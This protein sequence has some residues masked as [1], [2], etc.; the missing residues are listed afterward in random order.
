MGC[1]ANSNEKKEE[2]KNEPVND[3]SRVSENDM[4]QLN[5]KKQIRNIK[6]QRVNVETRA[7][8]LKKDAIKYKSE[9]NNSKAIY[10][11]KLKKLVEARL[12]KFDGAEL[13]LEQTLQQLQEATMNA[14]L[15]K[16]MEQGNT[17]IKELQ[18]AATLEDFQNIYD[19]IQE[20]QHVNDELAAALGVNSIDDAMFED[21]L[22][23]LEKKEAEIVNSKLKDAPKNPM[24]S[25]KKGEAQ[26]SI[27][28]ERE[29]VPA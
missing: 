27:E 3:K 5:L 1:L 8:Q 13:M 22:N 18:A 29:A 2:R 4:I 10:A 20:Q 6:E 23:D 21:E 15:K 25:A 24:P 14:D 16:V 17:A 7:Q 19:N 26:K 11:L 12:E 9:K 28:E